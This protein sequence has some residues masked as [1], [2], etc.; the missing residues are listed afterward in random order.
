VIKDIAERE[1]FDLIVQEV[2]FAGPR[3]DITKKVIDAL[4]A[5]K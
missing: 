3:V 4:N 2:I 5:A 1:R